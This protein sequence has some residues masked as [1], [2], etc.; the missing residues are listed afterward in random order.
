MSTLRRVQ[1]VSWAL[2]TKPLDTWH[3][4]IPAGW[5]KRGSALVFDDAN[6]VPPGTQGTVLGTD[7][8]GSLTVQ[9]DNGST[10]SL[11]P[12]QDTWLELE[13]S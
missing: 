13:K 2:T 8:A 11:L 5:E 9:W 3:G 10:I 1:A 7:G 6:T 4:H 12:G